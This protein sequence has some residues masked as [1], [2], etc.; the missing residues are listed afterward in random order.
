MP[1]LKKKDSLALIETRGA[2]LKSLTLAGKQVITPPIDGKP[3]HGGCAVLFP[4][5]NRVKGGLY[6]F[7]GKTFRL[8]TNEEGNAIHGLV[9]DTEWQIQSHTPSSIS[10][11]LRL[12][13][14]AYP[15][16]LK[17]CLTYSLEQDHLDVGLSV[18][19]EGDSDG[20][21]VVGFHPYFNVG[22]E[23]R[24]KHS[25]PLRRLNMVSHFPDGT[26]QDYDFNSLEEPW[27]LTFDDC[28]VGGGT[29]VLVGRDL[30][31]SIS[32]RNMEFFQLY[33]GVYALGS[34]ALEP[35][36][37]APD[38]YN[39][40]IGLTVIRPGEKLSCGFTLSIV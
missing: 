36:T 33:N 28:F 7:A 34:V 18:I 9:L 3:T 39:N 16:V 4:F 13:H 37:G 6:V 31:L 10:L 29:L 25:S 21:L 40:G 12:E 20:P 5:A 35:M 15:T 2:Y 32:R 11:S 26:F 30:K 23:W 38:A 22:K 1:E 24:L 8:P 14:R 27:K 17:T 19:N